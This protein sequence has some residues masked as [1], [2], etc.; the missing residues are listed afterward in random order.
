MSEDFDPDATERRTEAPAAGRREARAEPLRPYLR[1]VFAEA[2]PASSATLGERVWLSPEREGPLTVGRHPAAGLAGERWALPFDRSLSRSHFRLTWDGPAGDGVVVE[3]LGSSNGTFV[4]GAVASGRCATG[5]GGVVRAGGC[6]FVVGAAP[7]CEEQALLHAAG[8]RPPADMATGSWAIL[9]LW[10]RLVRYAASRAPLLLL[11]E[12]GSGKSWLA[13][14]IH[15]DS[16][17]AAGPLVVHN[18]AAIPA[19]SEELVLFG[20]A[21]KT[22]TQVDAKE[23]LLTQA[24]GGTLLL[25]EIGELPLAAQAKLLQALDTT[26]PSYTPL[27]APAPL[28]PTCRFIAATNG[29]V[30]ALVASGRLRGDLRSRLAAA[31]LRVPPLRERRED[32]LRILAAALGPALPAGEPVVSSAE[33]AE[34]LL[35]APWYENLRGLTRLAEAVRLGDELDVETV[36]RLGERGRTEAVAAAIAAGPAPRPVPKP[37]AAPDTVPPDGAPR[38]AEWRGAPWPLEPAELLT[39][40]ADHDWVIA[41]AARAVH[42]SREALSKRVAEAFGSESGVDAREN[43]K[44]AWRAWQ[45]PGRT[46]EED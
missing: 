42:R 5:V 45:R 12:M 10:K 14:T 34:A 33:V 35:L 7:A 19:G 39:L 17:R 36:R 23:G 43:A 37:A 41:A 13:R 3:D 32:I 18:C 1:L 2:L 30:D 15:A 29:D 6:V 44:K 22:Y 20:V 26:A 4:G 24:A 28:V 16:G 38:R 8:R 27:G 40:L 11:G 46:P 25:D 21:G 31:E 9:S